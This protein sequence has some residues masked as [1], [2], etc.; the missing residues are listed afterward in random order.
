GYTHHLLLFLPFKE[1]GLSGVEDKIN[2]IDLGTLKLQHYVD[3]IVWLPNFKFST[4]TD[5]RE[6]LEV[7][8]RDMFKKTSD[9]SRIS[10]SNGVTINEIRQ[11]AG[12]DIE[13]G[14]DK[15]GQLDYMSSNVKPSGQVMLEADHPFMFV[16]R[17][18][19]GTIIFIG[20]QL[21]Y[22]SSNV[23]PS[24]QVLL[25]ADHPFMFVIR[26]DTGTVIFIGRYTGPD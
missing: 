1:D 9:L 20:R 10:R 14:D 17:D 13:E 26:D 12:I 16:I 23:K 2:E 22:M 21:E 24:G 6:V 3:A 15:S 19:T 18:D 11:K 5:F 7:V 25:E 4:E 8:F